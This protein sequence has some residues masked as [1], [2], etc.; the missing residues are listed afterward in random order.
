MFL[1]FFSVSF[2]PEFHDDIKTDFMSIL[3]WE[4]I[5]TPHLSGRKHSGMGIF[6]FD[7]TPNK[8]LD[9]FLCKPNDDGDQHN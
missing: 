4:K 6:I 8:M 5:W 7:S 3:H 9:T 2:I 1:L